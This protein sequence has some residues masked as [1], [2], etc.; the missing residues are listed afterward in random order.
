M[1]Q[2]KNKKPN[3][4]VGFLLKWGKCNVFNFNKIDGALYLFF[5]CAIPVVVTIFSLQHVQEGKLDSTYWYVTVLIS[6]A[7]CFYDAINRWK[8][9]VKCFH[10]FKMLFIMIPTGVVVSYCGLFILAHLMDISI[11]R[12]DYALCAYFITVA[13]ALSDFII[14]FAREVTLSVSINEK[15]D[16]INKEPPSSDKIDNS[17]QNNNEEIK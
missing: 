10:N 11:P 5:Y 16:S 7:G 13:V 15:N 6:A 1:K 8:S 17:I 4:I 3:R 9:K 12:W 14:C 2:N